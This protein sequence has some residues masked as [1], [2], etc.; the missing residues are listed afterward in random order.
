MD[1][2]GLE[3]SHI[4]ILYPTEASLLRTS[5]R[6]DD[7]LYIAR[8]PFV[9]Y[10]RKNDGSLRK[11]TDP[12]E[13]KRIISESTLVS[14][15]FVGT[16]DDKGILLSGGKLSVGTPEEGQESI[17]GRGNSYPVP[18]AFHCKI[19]DTVDQT[20]VNAVDVSTILQSDTGSTTGLFGGVAAGDYI[21][22]GSQVTFGG[23]K[24]KYASVG[25]VNPEY[26]ISEYLE[27]DGAAWIS[28]PFMVTEEDPPLEQFAYNVGSAFREHIRFGFNPLRVGGKT[29]WEK[30]TMNINGE[31]ITAF[32]G[33]FRLLGTIAEDPVMEQLK[34]HPPRFE[35]N[36]NGMTE[37]FGD[38]RYKK[39][40]LTEQVAN[41]LK[42]PTNTNV[43][44]APGITAVGD[45]NTFN[46]SVSDGF[47]LKGAIP[48]GLDTSIPVLVEIDWY[49]AVADDGDVELQFEIVSVQRANQDFYYDGTHPILVSTSSILSVIAAD[50]YKKK[51]S[52]FLVPA[53][54][55]VPGDLIY[56]S[57]YRDATPANPHDTLAGSIVI[58]AARV[59]G[60]FWKP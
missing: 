5:I 59:F 49:S 28:V 7:A 50:Q 40:I 10:Y 27:E 38:A 56:A 48:E 42:N 58:T 1:P 60:Y 24:M 9:V 46:N 26:L 11:L 14:L 54:H 57:L 20:I 12:L 55:S 35:I 15:E 18:L 4:V 53:V 16:G 30:A 45:K 3:L 47:I 23:T 29:P 21:L 32:W 13:V 17:F 39:I 19:S 33:R 52:T 25:N 31:D 44:I 8:E 51:T 6:R 43:A 37:Y 36:S 34:L 41:A 22:V 2:R